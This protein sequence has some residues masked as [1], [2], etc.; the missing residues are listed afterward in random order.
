VSEC[1]RSDRQKSNPLIFKPYFFLFPQ[2]FV[3]FIGFHFYLINFRLNEE[4]EAQDTLCD[5]SPEVCDQ[6]AEV[7]NA[8]EAPAHRQEKH[9]PP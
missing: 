6:E 9:E 2:I 5:Q 3:I 8:V 4:K 7:Q 1:R